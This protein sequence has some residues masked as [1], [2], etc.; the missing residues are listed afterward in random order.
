MDFS[1]A[2]FFIQNLDETPDLKIEVDVKQEPIFYED[3]PTTSRC[4]DTI[5]SV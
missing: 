1:L 2:D 3:S 5:K 4:F